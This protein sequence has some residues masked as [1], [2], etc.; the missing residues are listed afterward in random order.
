M[1]SRS[2]H[3]LDGGLRLCLVDAKTGE[4]KKQVIHGD[5]DERDGIQVQS[6]SGTK[7]VPGNSEVLVLMASTST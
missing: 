4:L 7:M 2:H 3:F 1:L 5:K 6:K